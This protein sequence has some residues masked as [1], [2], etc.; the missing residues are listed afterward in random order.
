[1]SSERREFIR[2]AS[3][4]AI[5]TALRL[6]EENFDG[7]LGAAYSPQSFRS[8]RGRL[9][10]RA[11]PR[12][13]RRRSSFTYGEG[14]GGIVGAERSGGIMSPQYNGVSS[15][16]SQITGGVIRQQPTYVVQASGQQ[17]PMSYQGT[18]AQQQIRYA[19]VGGGVGTQPQYAVYPGQ[20]QQYIQ[21]PQQQYI[22][23]PQ[24][25]QFIQQQ[26]PQYITTSGQQTQY[27]SPGTQQQLQYSNQQP[28]YIS[29]AAA[30]YGG[31]GYGSGAGGGMQP[32]YVQSPPVQQVVYSG[33]QQ[34]G[35]SGGMGLGGR[36]TRSRALSVSSPGGYGY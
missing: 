4:A 3:E 1:V 14:V 6:E 36:Y 27:V 17:Q 15:I 7:D 12:A 29:T 28:Q 33:Q 5:A 25:Q 9:G 24:Q 21:Q 26:Q 30:G 32:R 2:E 19:Q 23:Q 20:Q 35:G 22:A 31:G 16:S 10:G 8:G 13:L 11:R 34:Y 18:G